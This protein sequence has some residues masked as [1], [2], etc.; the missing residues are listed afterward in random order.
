MTY[1]HIYL[2]QQKIGKFVILLWRPVNDFQTQ[3]LESVGIRLIYS[4]NATGAF[5]Q[6]KGGGFLRVQLID[7]ILFWGHNSKVCITINIL[8]KTNT[9]MLIRHNTI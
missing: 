7:F 1:E 4:S 6:P 2:Q 3:Q 5:L 9:H 8:F